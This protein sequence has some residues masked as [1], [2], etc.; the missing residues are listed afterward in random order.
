MHFQEP[1]Q[2]EKTA[3]AQHGQQKRSQR[4]V[5]FLQ[6]RRQRR[7]TSSSGQAERTTAQR[8]ASSEDV[9]VPS[10]VGAL[11]RQHLQ[12]FA[13]VGMDTPHKAGWNDERYLFIFDQVGHDLD[14][15]GLNLGWQIE[16]RIPVDSSRRIP[17]IGGGLSVQAWRQVR[18]N[19]VFFLQVEVELRAAQV[20][21]ELALVLPQAVRPADQPKKTRRPP[22]K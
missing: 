10:F 5:R 21:E 20:R 1:K 6:Q 2:V 3:F 15:G 7:A 17:L 19:E 11:H 8:R 4:K 16:R 14:H 18:P 22:P 9:D 13:K 12:H